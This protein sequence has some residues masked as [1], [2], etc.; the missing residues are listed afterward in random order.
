MIVNSLE[1]EMHDLKPNVSQ[2]VKY[3]LLG[4]LGMKKISSMMA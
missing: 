2:E 4:S 1:H 3:R